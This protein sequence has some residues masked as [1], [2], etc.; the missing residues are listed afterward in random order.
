M[1]SIKESDP[2]SDAINKGNK[3]MGKVGNEKHNP[4]KKDGSDGN[5]KDSNSRP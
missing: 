2:E 4:P 1:W 5:N 3:D